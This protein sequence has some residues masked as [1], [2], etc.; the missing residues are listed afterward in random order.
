MELSAYLPV[1]AS[2]GDA[3]PPH[4]SGDGRKPRKTVTKYKCTRD[5]TDLEFVC[6]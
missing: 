5:P 4:G 6:E 2:D 3:T 1:I